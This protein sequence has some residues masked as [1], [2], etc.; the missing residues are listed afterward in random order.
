VTGITLQI[1]GL[2][3]EPPQGL[4]ADSAHLGQT[5]SVGGTTR[6]DPLDVILPLDRTAPA[7]EKAAAQGTIFPQAQ[8]TVSVAGQQQ[9]FTLDFRNVIISSFKILNGQN[10]QRVEINLVFTPPRQDGQPLSA[11]TLALQGLQTTPPGGLR[12]DSLH[13]GTTIAVGQPLRPDPFQAVMSLDANAP[14]LELAVLRGTIF[15]T[16]QLTL[17]TSAGQTT[18]FAFRDVILTSFQVVEGLSGVPKLK[19]SFV[20]DLAS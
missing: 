13:M 17:E 10:S 7:L 18:T 5:F 15:P 6:F 14:A 16:G 11:I 19:F 1:Q 20:A 8:L 2:Q 9:P 3:G 12:L 4:A